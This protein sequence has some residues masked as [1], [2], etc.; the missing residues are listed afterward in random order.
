MIIHNVHGDDAINELCQAAM[1]ATM[2]QL[3]HEGVMTEDQVDAWLKEHICGMMHKD[4]GWH[5]WFARMFGKKD[6]PAA[7]V[8]VMVVPDIRTKSIT[9]ESVEY[10]ENDE[11][12]AGASGD[13]AGP[14]GRALPM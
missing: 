9:P 8:K 14:G 11:D 6:A 7:L 3:M 12:K 1:T 2:Y 10:D 4:G 13:G 5:N